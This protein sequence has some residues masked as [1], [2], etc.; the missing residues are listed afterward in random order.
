MK[1]N[2]L[3]IFSVFS[4]ATINTVHAEVF[5]LECQEEMLCNETHCRPPANTKGFYKVDLDNKI[6]FI[7]ADDRRPRPIKVT[8]E[9][10]VTINS[11]SFRKI[12]RL[13]GDIETISGKNNELLVVG[14]CTKVHA[15]F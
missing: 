15:K 7:D 11:G 5:V 8:D 4:L 6:L 1:K 10:I 14:T 2:L 12:N 13:S 9:Y 3:L